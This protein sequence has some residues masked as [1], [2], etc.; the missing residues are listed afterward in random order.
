M[1]VI[2]QR[3]G[4]TWDEVLARLGE[5]VDVCESARRH[6]A[7][8]RARIVRTGDQLLRLVLAYVLSGL[9]LR[10]TAAW[11]QMSGTARLSNVAL[12][13]RLRNCGPWLADM[14]S[15][16]NGRLCPEGGV[17]SGGYRVVAVDATMVCSPGGSHKPYRV[18]HTGLR[19]RGATPVKHRSDRSSCG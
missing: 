3:P 9:S 19:C 14:V 12:L 15:V 4:W 8:K 5:H 2:E 7:I 13:K 17:L 1:A 6:G 18:L 10:S 16:L 11:A